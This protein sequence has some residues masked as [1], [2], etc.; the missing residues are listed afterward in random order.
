MSFV[1]ANPDETD[2]IIRAIDK[3]GKSN[4]W[5]TV[6]TGHEFLERSIKFSAPRGGGR[7]RAIALVTDAQKREYNVINAFT[8]DE[9]IKFSAFSRIDKLRSTRM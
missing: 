3:R 1:D 4:K 2:V 9:F 8:V 5:V 6:S 7:Y